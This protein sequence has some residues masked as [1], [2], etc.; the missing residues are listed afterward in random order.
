MCTSSNVNGQESCSVA[1]AE[2]VPA[3]QLQEK[4]KSGRGKALSVRTNDGSKTNPTQ[5]TPVDGVR[6]KSMG[7]LEDYDRCS[8]EVYTEKNVTSSK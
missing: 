2:H 8:S 5:R 7:Y 6:I 1:N 4:L 3:G